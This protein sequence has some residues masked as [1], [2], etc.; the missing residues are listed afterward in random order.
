MN[1]T[2]VSPIDRM[3]PLRKFAAVLAVI[4]FFDAS[5]GRSAPPNAPASTQQNL[6]GQVAQ[7]SFSRAPTK[8]SRG[9][10]QLR[11][12]RPSASQA[13]AAA[14]LAPPP[15]VTTA[16]YQELQVAPEFDD[17]IVF[18]GDETL[19][20]PRD[21]VVV[22]DGGSEFSYDEAGYGEEMYYGHD[23][24]MGSGVLES[25]P[26]RNCN[27][28]QCRPP[29]GLFGPLA[30]CGV[31]V[32]AEYL[33][34]SLDAMDLPPLVTTSSINA[35]PSST[36][37]LDRPTTRTLFGG[38]LSEDYRSGGRITVGVWTDAHHQHA[39]E[40]S[41]LGLEN[42]SD[43][44]S[45]SSAEFVS[46]A[47]PVFDTLVGAESSMVVAHPSFLT[48][49]IRVDSSSELQ[50]FEVLR[51]AKLCQST[52]YHFDLLLGYKHASLDDMLRVDQSSDYF[53]A[54]GPIAAGTNVTLFDRF[55]TR[56]RFDGVV[57]GLERRHRWNCWLVGY[58]GKVSLGSN[59]AEALIDGQTIT[60]VPGAGSATFNGGLLAQQSN[61]G[62]RSRD[63]FIAIPE[64][65]FTLRRQLNECTRL[66]CGYSL[67]YW[68]AV[69]RVDDT[70][71]RRVSQ[72]PPE[73]ISGSAEPSFLWNNSDFLAHGFQVGLDYR[74]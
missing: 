74:F 70:I 50:A 33:A 37:V 63:E 36:G 13:S 8:L 27:C 30:G 18:E 53:A 2:P 21:E 64:F 11:S 16:N 44:F 24:P 68:S 25:L 29:V 58:T 73:P 19:P 59:Q 48:G 5:V 4:L 67:M 41:Y 7:R 56:N 35:T 20:A 31:W 51:R 45:T 57:L 39:W 60:T 28:A 26:H 1:S 72:F 52:F 46:L 34:W 38:E 14:A 9:Q 66:Q 12:R 17:A 6:P 65:T 42:T 69:S 40:V 43:R 61:I 23:D 55:E 3:Q 54:R 15:K 62:R 10:L 47:R 22:Q 71:S 49:S 32:S